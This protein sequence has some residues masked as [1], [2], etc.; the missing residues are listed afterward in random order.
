MKQLTKIYQLFFIMES[1]VRIIYNDVV[2]IVTDCYGIQLCDS[3]IQ[4]LWTRGEAFGMWI[5]I[6][7]VILNHRCDNW[8]SPLI[9]LAWFWVWFDRFTEVR[10]LTLTGVA[11]NQ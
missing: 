6:G 10:R 8:I 7:Y 9:G 3:S 2:I 5:N 4:A 1:P 11:T